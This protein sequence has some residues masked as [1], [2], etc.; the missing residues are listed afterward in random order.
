MPLMFYIGMENV[1]KKKK[2]IKVSALVNSNVK[3]LENFVF[4]F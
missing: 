2:I 3:L 4:F 1:V